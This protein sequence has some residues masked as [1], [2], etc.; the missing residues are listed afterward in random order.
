[1]I[2]IEIIPSKATLSVR[3]AVL[4]SG[5]PLSTCIFEGDDLETT[6][7]FGLYYQGELAGIISLFEN[8]N[9][10]FTDEKQFQ[11]RGMAVL[12]HFQKMGF[13]NLL[14][15]KTE[16]Y[17]KLKNAS[18]IWFNARETAVGFYQKLGYTII[19]TA[20]EI[21]NVGTHYVMHKTL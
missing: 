4:R 20:F 2:E 17:V 12:E 16:E 6:V 13:G 9:A 1:M 18:F 11:I 15:E 3:Q 10:I 7:H 19:G 5:K 14:V 21:E 8:K